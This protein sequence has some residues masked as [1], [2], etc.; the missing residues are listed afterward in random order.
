[1]TGLQPITT[2]TTIS[3]SPSS[4]V[5]GKFA[6]PASIEKFENLMSQNTSMQSTQ[7]DT[8]E[9]KQ[10]LRHEGSAASNAW[11]NAQNDL[12]E[13]LKK[14]ADL[15]ISDV[16]RVQYSMVK[17]SAMFE[18]TSKVAGMTEKGTESLFQRN[19]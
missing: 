3:T 1:M 4:E 8:S 14:G 7:G 18:L 13:L 10:F 16:M 11:T 6:A 19:S 12:N 15:S 17:T 5:N 2:Q 9:L